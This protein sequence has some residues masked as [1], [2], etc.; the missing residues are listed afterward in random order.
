M[1]H[2]RWIREVRVLKASSSPIRL[3]I[4]S[5]LFEKGP[6]SYTELMSSLK[7][8]PTQD[9][10]RFAY[11]L[12][13]LLKAN[14]IK[15]DVES[16]K[17]GL[18][19]LGEMVIKVADE[20][21]KKAF[22]PKRLLVRT[23]RFAL[24]EFDINKITDSLI[25][26]TKMPADLAHKIARET[27]KRLLKSKTKYLTA[28]LVREVVNAILIEKGLEEYRHELTRLGLPVHDIKTLLETS[29]K[30]IQRQFSVL[31]AAGKKVLEEYTLLKVLPRDMADAHISGSLHINGL[32]QWILKP[33]EIMHDLRFFL[34]NGLNLENVNPPQ[35]SYP[36]PKS[37]DSALSTTL[38]ILLHAA[39]ETDKA[40]TIDYFNVFLAPFIRNVNPLKVKEKLRLFMFNVNQQLNNVSL[41]IEL[42]IPDFIAEKQAFGP[43]GKT[44]GKYGDFIVEN[45]LIALQV[46]EIL[47][48]ETL[49]KPLFNPKIIIKVRSETFTDENAEQLLLKAHT[50]ATEKGVPYF[51][52]LTKKRQKH[53]VFSASGVKLDADLKGDW[54]IDTLRTGSL[55]EVTVNLPR[56]TCE[57]KGK[58]KE[59]FQILG[60]RLEMTVRAFEIKYR[61]LKQ[62]FKNSLPFLSLKINGDQYFRLE[63][64]SRL[65]SFTGVREAA[66]AF[67]GK[68]IHDNEEKLGFIKET[69]KCITN[70]TDKVNKRR[71]K[72][73][74]PAILPNFEASERLASLDIERYG[75][76]KVQFSGTRE[77]PF[78][79][80][81]NKLTLKNGK[82]P[83]EA[84]KMTQS[85]RGLYTGGSLTT[86]DLG[87]TE[88]EAEELTSLTKQIVNAYGLEFF[89]YNRNLTY[90]VRCKKSWL[91]LLSKC[92]SCGATSTLITFNKFA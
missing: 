38:N 77:K 58:R 43:L 35:P 14:L 89:T 80:T 50:L 87:E 68:S 61:M 19:E 7:M 8:N 33:N 73:L 24:E 12:K 65:V 53:S 1:S 60:D 28:P 25:K 55:G 79:S 92:P 20:I 81:I 52:N 72:R 48:E 63:N 29:S 56:I 64:S 54:E 18:T 27:E 57:S 74:L 30:P 13:F 70:F 69:V 71:R 5:I 10:G 46:L 66:E 86:I 47:M 84:L 11:H 41:G 2:K 23:S 39:K 34:R 26:E 37:L 36:P 9:A 82:I 88:Y 22:K 90:C 32:S 76:A 6:L 75:V 51:A 21:E 17:Y 31:E 62:R 40:Q 3:R 59:F 83:S 78:Y 15:T 16:K 44:D 49:H 85:L 91:G 42:S 45:Q 67:Y 4:L